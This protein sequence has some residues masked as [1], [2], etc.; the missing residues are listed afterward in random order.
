[1]KKTTKAIMFLSLFAVT[2]SFL[3]IMKEASAQKLGQM[4]MRGSYARADESR[5]DDI[6]AGNVDALGLEGISDKD[7]YGISTGVGIRAV[8]KDPWFGQEIWGV[9]GLEYNRF[10][11]GDRGANLPAVL[12]NRFGL[13]SKALSKD[14]GLNEEI[15]TAIFNVQIGPRI[16]F[17]FGEPSDKLF[18]LKRLH[19]FIGTSM[20][21]GVIS[22]PSDDVTYI[23]IGAMV[24]AGF[25][26]VLPPLGGLFSIGADYRHHFFGGATGTNMDY[27]SA[28]IAISVNF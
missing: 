7:G 6:L 4:Y 14:S 2:F 3:A 12:E 1:M 23:D 22:P 24:T 20:M 15:S 5:S 11:D 10:G 26:Y 25:D 21:F 16:R 17:V 28:G 19:P 18:D 13:P 9:V 8:P 27:G